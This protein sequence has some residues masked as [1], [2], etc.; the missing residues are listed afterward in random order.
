LFLRVFDLNA[1]LFFVLCSKVMF[2]LQLTTLQKYAHD[3]YGLENFG[4]PFFEERRSDTSLSMANKNWTDTPLQT[5]ALTTPHQSNSGHRESF[6][7]GVFAYHWHNRFGEEFRKHSI[8]KLFW[9][10]F[11][12]IQQRGDY[13]SK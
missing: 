3:V 1:F 5:S 12:A 4:A 11:E 10:H 2:D 6:F 8:A 7:P 13:L 9:D